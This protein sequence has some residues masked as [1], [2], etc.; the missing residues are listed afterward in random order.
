MHD[1]CEGVVP[2]IFELIITKIAT[3]YQLDLS[4]NR[5]LQT[6]NKQI[7]IKLFENFSFFEGQP[8]LKWVSANGKNRFKLSGSALQ[9]S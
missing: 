3:T 8:S 6:T 2:A 9:V 5:V 7:I 1:L 4:S